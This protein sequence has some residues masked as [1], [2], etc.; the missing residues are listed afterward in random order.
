MSSETER[1]T[2]EVLNRHDWGKFEDHFDTAC[3][4]GAEDHQRIADEFRETNR[5]PA[6]PL[7]EALE[8]PE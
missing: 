3:F 8:L 4:E 6:G 7:E 1:I 2:N 5:H